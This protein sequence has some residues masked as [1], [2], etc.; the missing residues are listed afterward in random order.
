LLLNWIELTF[1]GTQLLSTTLSVKEYVQNEFLKV[2][3]EIIYPHKQI[4]PSPITLDDFFWAFG[5]LRSRAFSRLRGQNL[6]LIPLADLVKHF[7][8]SSN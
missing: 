4:F 5:I 2:E 1:P 7:F 8:P 3:E 6:V